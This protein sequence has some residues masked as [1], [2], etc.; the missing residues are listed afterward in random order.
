MVSLVQITLSDTMA[1]KINQTYDN[2]NSRFLIDLKESIR[3]FSNTLDGQFDEVPARKLSR[4]SE[5]CGLLKFGRT[6]MVDLSTA[7]LIDEIVNA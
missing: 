1:D 2:E 5:L 4:L 3:Q 6:I 7:R